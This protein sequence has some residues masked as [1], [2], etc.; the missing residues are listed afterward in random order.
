MNIPNS[1]KVFPE[2]HAGWVLAE[3]CEIPAQEHLPA[4]DLRGVLCQE[5]VLE[6]LFFRRC[7]GIESTGCDIALQEF[8]VDQ[9][10]HRWDE[11]F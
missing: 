1:G 5:V 2:L 7:L 3:P 6:L 10:S 8:P 9:T 4:L 11:L